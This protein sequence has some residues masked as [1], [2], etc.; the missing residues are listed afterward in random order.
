[1]KLSEAILKGCEG[2][3][4]SR[5]NF[6]EGMECCCSLGA[7][8]KTLAPYLVGSKDCDFIVSFLE[9]KF[10][11]LKGSGDGTLWTDIIARNANDSRENVAAWLAEKGL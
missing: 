6:F 3:T 8:V 9:R 5:D 7:A 10:P 11:E 4:Q 2:T 1:M